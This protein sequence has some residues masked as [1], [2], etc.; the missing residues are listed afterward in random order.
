[1]I[2]LAQPYGDECNSLLESRLLNIIGL[3]AVFVGALAGGLTVTA[4][5]AR[6]TFWR[7]PGRGNMFW[8]VGLIV[9]ACTCGAAGGGIVRD[10]IAGRPL[11]FWREPDTVL[12]VVGAVVSVMVLVALAE[13]LFRTLEEPIID[14][15]DDADGI[16]LGIFGVMGMEL[17]LQSAGY[18]SN[19]LLRTLAEI[20][21]YSF[22]TSAGGGF[23]RD[24]G[25]EYVNPGSSVNFLRRHRLA[26][27]RL[28]ISA[29][30]FAYP[31]YVIS[32]IVAKFLWNAA[33][34]PLS[35]KFYA[36]IFS[37]G[38]AWPAMFAYYIFGMLAG[39]SWYKIRL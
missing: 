27:I 31:V 3:A 15:T 29:G 17:A 11:L 5:L 38:S 37:C 19:T 33:E 26:Y 18:S 8:S 21:A 16:C 34:T 35:V 39:W 13:R 4:Q 2:A 24:I 30:L 23:V 36:M 28:G 22:F 12:S 32:P 20:G 1:M 14:L 7:A 6:G 10:L 9:F 25:I